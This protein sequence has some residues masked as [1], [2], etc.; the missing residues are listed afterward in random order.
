MVNGM[1]VYGWPISA[2]V[3]A[4][5]WNSQR[6]TRF[7]QEGFEIGQNRN[8]GK[9][10]PNGV[11]GR[12]SRSN[13]YAGRSYAEA[14]K[15]TKPTTDEVGRGLSMSW[16]G[17]NRMDDWLSKSAV[18]TLK[19]F[20]SVES[21]NQKLEARGFN[22]SSTFMGGKQIVWSFESTCDRDGFISNS[23][24]WRD[25]FSSMEA[26]KEQVRSSSLDKIRWI[27]IHGVPLS[28]WYANLSCEVTV[29]KGNLFFPVKLIEHHV[30]VTDRWVNKVLGLRPGVSNLNQISSWGAFDPVP[31]GKQ[32][33]FGDDGHGVREKVGG[34][35]KVMSTKRGLQESRQGVREK[36]TGSSSPAWEQRDGH[37]GKA[38]KGKSRWTQCQKP[39][40]RRQIREG[41]VKIDKVR[42]S[43]YESSTDDSESMVRGGQSGFGP[44]AKKNL[45]LGESS[46]RQNG[47]GLAQDSFILPY[48]KEKKRPSEISS[49]SDFSSGDVSCAGLVRKGSSGDVDEGLEK[50][51]NLWNRADNTIL[52]NGRNLSSIQMVQE[53]QLNHKQ[54][55]DI[56]VDLRSQDINGKESKGREEDSERENTSEAEEKSQGQS[57]KGKKTGM[58]DSA[59]LRKDRKP[60][61]IRGQSSVSPFKVQHRMVNRRSHN[62]NKISISKSKF[63]KR[64]GDA[65]EEAQG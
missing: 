33:L 41:G 23:F 31:V 65:G 6:T 1:H 44:W 59:K 28:C 57:I 43:A 58:G 50:D 60:K 14:V 51:V 22:F 54:G 21:V 52:S 47:S 64:V 37:M 49:D 27:D 3:A 26:W 48:Q 4:H 53:T 63:K 36:S 25:C 32:R 15:I 12:D 17:H 7:P 38:D 19:Q 10:I 62:S 29:K 18:G 61:K 30:P 13:A 56:V 46:K 55:I 5:D 2:K 20:E 9:V 35:K 16:G 34:T 8:F 40:L 39:T 11:E 45:I 24:F 42:N